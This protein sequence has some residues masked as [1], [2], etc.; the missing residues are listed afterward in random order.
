MREDVP[1]PEVGESVLS[2]A[3]LFSEVKGRK[4]WERAV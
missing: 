4:G 3:C 2:R 1:N